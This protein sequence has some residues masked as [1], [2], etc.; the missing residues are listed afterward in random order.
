MH[1]WLHITPWYFKIT[2]FSYNVLSA[3]IMSCNVMYSVILTDIARYIG[4][5]NMM[6]Q[7]LLT[8]MSGANTCMTAIPSR[9]YHMYQPVGFTCLY[10]LFTLVYPMFGL[11]NSEGQHMVYR[12]LNWAEHPGYAI[13]VSTLWITLTMASHII[14]VLT[15]WSRRVVFRG[16]RKQ[17]R[18]EYGM[19][20]TEYS[21]LE[22][23]EIHCPQHWKTSKRPCCYKGCLHEEGPHLYPF[24]NIGYDHHISYSL[25]KGR[26]P[27]LY[28]VDRYDPANL[29]SSFNQRLAL[30]KN[31]HPRTVLT[32]AH[33]EI[34]EEETDL[35]DICISSLSETNL[36]G[37]TSCRP[38]TFY[39]G[40]QQLKSCS[41]L[42]SPSRF[43]HAQFIK[44]KSK[45]FTRVFSKHEAN[46][47]QYIHQPSSKGGAFSGD[48]VTLERLRC[49]EE[50]SMIEYE[51][52]VDNSSD[53]ESLD[54]DVESEDNDDEHDDGDQTP[55][56]SYFMI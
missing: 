16:H 30:L 31:V 52:E 35:Q 40:I 55:S 23:I 10:L 41:V 7:I 13:L 33:F 6:C 27:R 19:D 9:L 56:E 2:W 15:C 48:H 25:A 5:F 18:P 8:V 29:P 14:C 21:P 39:P 3:N 53:E 43:T 54:E 50:R 11:T 47:P 36:H 28:A 1:A 37:Q 26:R 45:V 46:H 17:T 49:L 4:Y 42:S 34:P 24:H 12:S 51:D 38:K 20:V 32:N 44:S 22:E